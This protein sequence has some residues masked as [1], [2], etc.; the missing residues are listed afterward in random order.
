MNLRRRT[1][2]RVYIAR[3][4]PVPGSMGGMREDFAA[5]HQVMEGHLLPSASSLKPHTAG[6]HA[7]ES[8]LLLLSPAADIRVG[9]GVGFAQEAIAYRVTRC[10]R[11]S[12]HLCVHLEARK[13]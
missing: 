9:D 7:K 4:Q 13:S 12:L 10:D 6:L 1:I 11:Y 2:K 5:P 8:C 3:P